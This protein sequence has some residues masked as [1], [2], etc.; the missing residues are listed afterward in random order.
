MSANRTACIVS[1]NGVSDEPRVIR[2]AAALIQAGWKVVV[3]G[4][5]SRSP[6]PQGW[7]FVELDRN[8]VVMRRPPLEH[9]LKIAPELVFKFYWEQLGNRYVYELM[10]DIECDAIFA[11]DYF[12]APIAMRLA[13]EKNI[14]FSVD[15]HEY[16]RAQF[17]FGKKTKDAILWRLLTRPYIDAISRICYR[18]A[19]LVTTVC[20]GIA[21]LLQSEYGLK[22]RPTVVRSVPFYEKQG[23]RPTGDVIR[24][25]YHGLLVP[26]RGLEQAISS[27]PMWKPEY[28]LVIRGIGQDDYI[29]SL[30]KLAESMSVSDRVDF[31]GPSLLK[32]LVREANACDIG[33]VVLPNYSP[34][35]QFTL[36]NKFFEYITAGTAL[37]ASDLPELAR[38]VRRYDLGILVPDTDPVNIAAAINSFDRA[39]IDFHKRQSLATAYQLCWDRESK[40]F[41]D[42]VEFSMPARPIRHRAV[43]ATAKSSKKTKGSVLVLHGFRDLDS[44]RNTS[45]NHLFSYQRYLPEN[46]FVYHCGHE[47]ITRSVRSIEFSAVILD[48]SFLSQRT[49]RPRD[50]FNE[51]KARW[52]WLADVPAIKVALPQDEYDHCG[53]LDE[54]LSELRVDIVYSVLRH[55]DVLYPRT[56][57]SAKILNALTGYVESSET[58]L[59]EKLRRP[60]RERP[61]DLGYRARDLSFHYGRLGRLKA[62]IHHRF[63]TVAG[64]KGFKADTAISPDHA[65][66][67]EDWLRFI[68]DCRFMP[69]G[70]SGVS[71]MDRRGEI[72]DQTLAYL[73]AHPTAT[74]EEVEAACFP[75]QDQKYIFSAISP[76]L[77]EAAAAGTC[78]I[79]IAGYDYVGLEPDKHYIPLKVDFSNVSEV[80]ERMRD[81]DEAQKIA[82]R[83]YDY[84]IGSGRF[85]YR[86]FAED[87]FDQIRATALAKGLEFRADPAHS[88]KVRSHNFELVWW[89]TDPSYGPLEKVA[90]GVLSRYR[91]TRATSQAIVQKVKRA[92][93]QT[94]ARYMKR[95]SREVAHRMSEFAQGVRRVNKESLK[96]HIRRRLGW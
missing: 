75:G 30:K 29:D 23:F 52:T 82:D 90:W 87:V 28:R 58:A 51:Y 10:R 12:T 33:Y 37:C 42:A 4:Y 66:L 41:L 34:Q 25:L 84:L 63:A 70:P 20:D 7:N 45:R 78:Q 21:D 60:L 2:Q 92:I 61:I 72:G 69:A 81:L 53:D 68:A 88:A 1:L 40:V 74:F 46:D 38:V 19:A 67:G 77:F 11:H 43:E 59:L 62:G 8:C 3:V 17:Y 71:V 18:R 36:P 16:A 95:N 91:K 56:S 83:C 47:R 76:R 96:R 49:M 35:R 15:C 89:N 22:A 31:I 94:M 27:I 6:I 44:A 54:W 55:H 48:T 65:I 50:H 93:P 13:D 5:R 9:A 73:E 80:F 39:R 57:C 26:T 79:L 85:T 64:R 14:P 32:D 86:S 24:V